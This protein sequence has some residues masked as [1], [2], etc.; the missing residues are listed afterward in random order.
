M[1]KAIKYPSSL[2]MNLKADILNLERNQQ[3]KEKFEKTIKT[4]KRDL[5]IL[6]NINR[7]KYLSEI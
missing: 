1:Q 6:A 5:E 4:T 3:Q 2:I 7:G